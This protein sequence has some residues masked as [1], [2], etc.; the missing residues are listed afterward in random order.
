MKPWIHDPS[1]SLDESEGRIYDPSGSLDK[2]KGR[3]HDPSGSSDKS[4][5]WRLKCSERLINQ[6]KFDFRH[7]KS[8]IA[9][10]HDLEP[11][12][13]FLDDSR[14]GSLGSMIQVDLP[15]K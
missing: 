4:S 12:I 13:L 15:T 11:V 8:H 5:F 10:N 3:I 7:H 14:L 9:L 2:T 1:G 6:F